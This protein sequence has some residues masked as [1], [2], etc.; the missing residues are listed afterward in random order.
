MDVFQ[1]SVEEIT[2]RMIDYSV[3]DAYNILKVSPAKCSSPTITKGP[4]TSVCIYQAI[5]RS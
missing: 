1:E 3:G 5:R 2:N 4:P